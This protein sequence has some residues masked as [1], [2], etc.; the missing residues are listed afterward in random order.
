VLGELRFVGV[1]APAALTL[2]V[3]HATVDA[4]AFTQFRFPGTWRPDPASQQVAV[5]PWG[6]PGALQLQPAQNV[7]FRLDAADPADDLVFTVHG[8]GLDGRA[9]VRVQPGQTG[10]VVVEVRSQR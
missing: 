10:A 6:G 2:R 7:T 8:E 9:T 3:A 1:T 5:D 4:K